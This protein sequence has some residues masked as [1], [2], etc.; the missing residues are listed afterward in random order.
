MYEV[1]DEVMDETTVCE[2]KAEVMSH[3]EYWLERL[4]DEREEGDTEY[5]MA[6]YEDTLDILGMCNVTV[7]EQ[8]YGIYDHQLGGFKED[9]HYAT[10]EEALTTYGA[11]LREQATEGVDVEDDTV[12]D[13][14][15]FEVF[16]YEV[17]RFDGM[18]L[19]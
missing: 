18:E 6:T 13:E 1:T 15:L 3:A 16:Q 10:K 14:T 9:H 12:S 8:P 17:Q 4:N 7:T 11:C 19:R 5:T 2:T